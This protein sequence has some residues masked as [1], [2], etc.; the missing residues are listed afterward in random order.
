MFC[1]F[2]FCPVSTLQ[3]RRMVP[4][5][6]G[7]ASLGVQ[8]S[9]VTSGRCAGNHLTPSKPLIVTKTNT[10]TKTNE[11]TKTKAKCIENPTYAIFSKSSE[12]KD[13]KFDQT[14]PFKG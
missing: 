14:N 4:T 3:L 7:V 11:K 13:I 1:I 9:T 5:A 2:V 6:P 12:F 8:S 10:K